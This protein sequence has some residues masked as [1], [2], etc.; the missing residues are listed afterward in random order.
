VRHC[1]WDTT[2]TLVAAP[3]DGGFAAPAPYE[4]VERGRDWR[5]DLAIWG[6]TPASDESFILLEASPRTVGE[7]PSRPSDL[8]VSLPG[9][10]GWNAPVPLAGRVNTQTGW[11]NFATVTPDGCDLVFVRDFSGF[12][13]VSLRDALPRQTP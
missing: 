13:R 11:E 6:G 3:S 2:T 1:W 4:P 8:W 7:R 10:G 12:Y 9:P 5:A